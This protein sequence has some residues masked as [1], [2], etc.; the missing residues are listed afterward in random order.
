MKIPQLKSNDPVAIKEYKLIS[1]VLISFKGNNITKMIR[2]F[3]VIGYDVTYEGKHPLLWI[4]WKGTEYY[5]SLSST[6]SDVNWQ[7]SAL[8]T[9]K[10]IFEK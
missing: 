10:R 1:D 3:D 4:T 9:I 5:V 7:K 2:K 6:P 8:R